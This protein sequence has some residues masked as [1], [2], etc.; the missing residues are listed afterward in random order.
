MEGDPEGPRETC[1]A[2]EWKCLTVSPTVKDFSSLHAEH[3]RPRIPGF[4]WPRRAPGTKFLGNLGQYATKH[5]QILCHFYEVI[6]QS[7][8]CL[9]VEVLPGP[10]AGGVHVPRGRDPPGRPGP[11]G[12]KVQ[13]EE[14]EGDGRRTRNKW[15]RARARPAASTPTAATLARNRTE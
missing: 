7:H 15:R 12:R 4:T 11:R 6:S 10:R 2:C 9:P 14:E 3:G 5:Y 8:Y 1:L 13:R